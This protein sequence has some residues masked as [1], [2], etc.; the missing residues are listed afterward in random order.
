MQIYLVLAIPILIAT[1]WLYTARVARA[2][3]SQIRSKR[4]C[5]LIAHPD[6]EAMFFSP[7]LLALTSEGLGNHVKILCLSTGIPASLFLEPRSP[8]SLS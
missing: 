1:A 3:C 4:I 7:T 6:D 8:N 5:L 2:S